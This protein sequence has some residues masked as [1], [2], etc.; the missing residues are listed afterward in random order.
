MKRTDASQAVSLCLLSGLSKDAAA[1]CN[2]LISNGINSF[3]PF[4]GYYAVE[5]LAENGHTA[6]AMDMIRDYWGSMIDLGAT[7]FWEDLN[8]PDTKNAARIDEIVPEGKY[9]IHSQGGAYCYVGLRLSLCHGWAAGPTAWL[10]RHVLGINPIEPGCKTVEV[11]PELGPL[12][13][14]E[15]S[16]PTPYGPLEVKA[17][18]DAAGKTIVSVK[19]PKGVKVKR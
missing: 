19:A 6:K 16:I 15:G 17:K 4:Y 2:T 3:S 12:A 8:Y 5:A 1:D 9:D 10:Q 11:K 18:K 14:A 7:T 13:Y